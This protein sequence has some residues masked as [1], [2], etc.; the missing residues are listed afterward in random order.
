MKQFVIALLI[1]LWIPIALHSQTTYPIIKDSLVVITP[2]QLKT[3]NLIF[4]EHEMLLKKVP[5]LTN[6]IIALEELNNTYIKQDSLRIKEIDLYKNAY[7]ERD[8]Q[9]NKLNKKYKC[10]KTYSILGGIAAFV[11]GILV[12]R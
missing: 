10:Y 6:Q 12:C 1:S 8:L 7:E 3:T 11:L 4:S 2:Q 9:Y 5:L